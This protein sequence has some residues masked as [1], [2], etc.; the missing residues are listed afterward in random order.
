MDSGRAL[1][2]L[3]ASTAAGCRGNAGARLRRVTQTLLILGATGDLTG[4]LLL[5]GLGGL[6]ATGVGD[7]L[8]ILGSGT[9]DWDDER[10]RKRV[11]DSFARAKASGGQVETVASGARYIQ[12]DAT[13]EGDLHRLLDACEGTAIVYFALPPAVT[14][15]AC[16]V[17]T[18]TGLPDGTRL[19]MEKPFGNDAASAE[20]LRLRARAARLPDLREGPTPAARSCPGASYARRAPARFPYPTPGACAPRGPPRL[21]EGSRGAGSPAA[22]R[23][24]GRP[25]RNGRLSGG[26]SRTGRVR[27]TTTAVCPCATRSGLLGWRSIRWGPTFRTY[28]RRPRSAKSFA[29][30]GGLL[31]PRAK[32]ARRVRRT[33]RAPHSRSTPASPVWK[34]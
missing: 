4:R 9:Q 33:S 7:G 8:M 16:E 18:R 3:M 29:P 24:D 30:A 20:A 11:A 1:A 34:R 6:L 15:K 26:C 10:W 17:L 23:G 21:R 28:Q 31:G 22:R 5:P 2:A 32:S 25:T 14:D 27:S 12:G 19:V 13:D